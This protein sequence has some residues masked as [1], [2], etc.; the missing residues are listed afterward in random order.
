MRGFD[1][2]GEMDL[3][4][5]VYQGLGLCGKATWATIPV[6]PDVSYMTSGLL[7]QLILVSH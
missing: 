2:S 3:S 5:V 6:F 4:A 7:I 1:I